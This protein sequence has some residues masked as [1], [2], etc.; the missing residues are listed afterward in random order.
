MCSTHRLV[1]GALHRLTAA[2]K[3]APDDQR[4][5]GQLHHGDARLDLLRELVVPASNVDQGLVERGGKRAVRGPDS[6]RHANLVVFDLEQL[7]VLLNPRVERL[8]D[9]RQAL[10]VMQPGTV[11]VDAAREDHEH[12]TGPVEQHHLALRGWVGAGLKVVRGHCQASLS[13]APSFRTNAR[14]LCMLKLA[15]PD[16]AWSAKRRGQEVGLWTTS[17]GR[18]VARSRDREQ[19][20]GIT[21]AQLIHATSTQR[22]A[23]N[24]I[25]D[26]QR[27]MLMS[28]ILALAVVVALPSAAAFRA[29]STLPP[30]AVTR[31]RAPPPLALDPAREQ[32]VKGGLPLKFAERVS[33]QS[34]GQRIPDQEKMILA[35]WKEFKKCY[36]SEEVA[37]EMLS[38]NT[39]VILP[40]LNS[41][42]KI[43]ATCPHSPATTSLIFLISELKGRGRT[44]D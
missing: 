1:H 40:Q 41:P 30:R 14:I 19:H 22:V 4:H 13:K 11:A 32:L 5:H 18:E 15:I 9:Q 42:A 25:L 31:R 17:R 38:K 3:R 24:A 12:A 23:R 34:S 2:R 44:T 36:K 27:V 28:R 39:A 37:R 26:R 29:P 7:K 43:K 20:P 33:F 21:S 6:K 16:R 10:A 35:L 8:R